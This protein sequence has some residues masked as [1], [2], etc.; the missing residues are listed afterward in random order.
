MANGPLLNGLG[1][2]QGV[3]AIVA[4]PAASPEERDLGSTATR[5]GARADETVRSVMPIGGAYTLA[6]I[7]A[8][9]AML[10]VACRKCDRRGRPNVA[11]LI[12]QHG[13]DARLPDLKDALA[14]DCPKRGSP[15]VHD[16]CG[17]YYPGLAILFT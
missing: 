16:R 17:V 14:G 15:A 9:A 11:R 3:P 4:D 8:Q 6:D 12:R 7:A 10:E 13:A 1:L 5:R 2:C